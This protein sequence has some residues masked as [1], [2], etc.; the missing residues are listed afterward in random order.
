M[1]VKP[2]ERCHNDVLNAATDLDLTSRTNHT[3]ADRDKTVMK[4]KDMKKVF[5]TGG[6]CK[7]EFRPDGGSS[8]GFSSYKCPRGAI[9]HL[10][11]NLSERCLPENEVVDFELGLYHACRPQSHSQNVH[12]C[13]HV[14]C[15]S[16]ASHVLKETAKRGNGGEDRKKGVKKVNG[17]G[18]ARG[19][20]EKKKR[21]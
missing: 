9:Q 6:P 21:N 3:A 5:R 2:S 20:Q 15:R 14:V 12:L 8:Q 4:A 13:W 17:R 11:K 16:D 1:S 19:K 7:V 10:H 18:E